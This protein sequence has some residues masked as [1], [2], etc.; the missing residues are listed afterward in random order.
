VLALGHKKDVKRRLQTRSLFGDEPPPGDLR[1]V[2]VIP[3]QAAQRERFTIPTNMRVPV[4]S[5]IHRLF[6]ADPMTDGDAPEDL[7]QWESQG[8]RLESRRVIMQVRKV[9]DRVIAIA[10]PIE[11]WRDKRREQTARLFDG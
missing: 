10:Q 11:P 6:D 8:R 5:V 3:N 2:K 4:D 7:S 9:S 1:A